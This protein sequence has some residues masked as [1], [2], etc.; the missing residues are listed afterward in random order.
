FTLM[1]TWKTG[2]V[3][4]VNRLRAGTLPLTM[5]L[6][7]IENH[8]PLRV[9]GTAIFLSGNPDG[10][11]LAFMHNL[12]HIKVLHDKVIIMTVQTAERPH[13]DPDERVR[14]EKLRDNFYRVIGQFGFMED[15]DVPQILES[16]RVNALEID[17][18][19]ATFFL[20]RETIIATPRPGMFIWRE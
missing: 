20:S 16:C 4:L 13:V 10:T 11:P 18:E 7:D 12:K 19:K 9:P 14:V 8:P 6:D 2:R 15:P 1:A 17:E 3:I 5:F